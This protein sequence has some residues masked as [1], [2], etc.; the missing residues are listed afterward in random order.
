MKTFLGTF[1]TSLK[2]YPFNT[3]EEI[4]VGDIL[5]VEGYSSHISVNKVYNEVFNFFSYKTGELISG[6]ELLPG[7]GLIKTV[8]IKKIESE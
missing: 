8:I 3:E 6:N 1:K 2:A 4:E 7:M 5:E